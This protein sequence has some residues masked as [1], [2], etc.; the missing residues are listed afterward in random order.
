MYRGKRV[1]VVIPAYNEEGFVGRVIE[2]LPA[3][4]DRVYV[5][6]DASTDGTWTQI[7]AQRERHEAAAEANEK[8]RNATDGAA[9]VYALPSTII[10]YRQQSN[11]GRGAAI[12]WGY[13]RALDDGMDLV[14]VMD[15]DGQMDGRILGAVLDPVVDGCAGYAKGTRLADGASHEGM[16]PWRL[17]GNHLLTWLTRIASGYG[18]M[19]DPQNGYTAVSRETLERIDIESLFDDYGFC[20]D[21]LTV[22][23]VNRERVADVKMNAVYGDEVSGIR[24][25]R[26]VPRLS[27]LLAR[28]FAGRLRQSY[29]DC[30]S[31]GV[32]T[33]YVVG[34]VATLVGLSVGVRTALSKTVA[35]DLGWPAAV[36]LVGVG[37]GTLALAIHL[38]LAASAELLV[39]ADATSVRSDEVSSITDAPSSN[40][41]EW[42]RAVDSPS[43]D[44][45]ASVP[46][47]TVEAAPTHESRSRVES[48]PPIEPAS[49]TESTSRRE[50]SLTVE[51]DEA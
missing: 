30:G 44:A 6:D 27:R 24:Y 1:A 39:V 46:I 37:I 23:N 25:S 9:A 34:P 18:R 8:N 28:R 15:G 49:P 13:R 17:F 11:R 51:R 20:N 42:S 7:S 48:T 50:P 36:G 14:A 35:T 26:F 5:V 32:V 22:L 41:N 45:D 10:A 31:Y 40:A 33:L 29:L 47:P 19:T 43:P 3:F 2:S 12:K 4:V 16:S 38:D 21:V